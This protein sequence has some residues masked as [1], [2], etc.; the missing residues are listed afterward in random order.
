MELIFFTAS[1][2]GDHNMVAYRFLYQ[3]DISTAEPK[4]EYLAGKILVFLWYMV[5][6]LR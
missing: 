5:T 2:G 4:S 3:W 6:A 1:V